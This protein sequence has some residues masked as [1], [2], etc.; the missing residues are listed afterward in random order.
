L[1]VPAAQFPRRTYIR[2]R[3]TTPVNT[4]RLRVV[5]RDVEPA[6]ARVIDVPA[7]ATLPELHELLQAAIGWTD[8]HSTS[9]SRRRQPTGWRFPERRCGPRTSV[10]KPVPGW[11]ISAPSSNTST[12]SA[13]AGTHDV[14]VLGRGGS[15]PGC[16]DG[17]G[18]CPP[19]DC[20]GPGGYAELLDVLPDPAHPEHEHMRTWVGNRLRPF[21][22]A[23][24]DQWVRRVVGEVP[25]SVGLLLDFAADG[26]K[27][28]PGGRL[29]RTVVR[30]M[31]QHRPHWHPLG[32]PAASEDDLPPLGALH[33]LLRSVGL[34][35][36][37]HGVL[38]PT[39]AAGDDLAIVRRL[40]SAFDAY[41][42]A[43]EITE[44]TIGG[45]RR[46]RSAPTC[47]A[48]D[49]GASATRARL[50]ARRATHQRA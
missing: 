46:A 23:A 50:A 14:E 26:I 8:S 44:L 3:G 19:E 32:R 17:H 41:T 42:F 48:R 31:Q 35:R 28:T 4:A 16:V 30:S 36:L 25:E 9:S 1:L 33:G 24:T 27:L 43:T 6:V 39:R 12:T 11:P 45:A 49:A 29:P 47:R 34:L 37:R 7:S 38:T 22:R 2:R 20:G 10:T 21:D 18:A 5:L 15:A 40:R 13:T